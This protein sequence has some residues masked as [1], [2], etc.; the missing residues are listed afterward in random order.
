MHT[1]QYKIHMLKISEKRKEKS[2]PI[3]TTTGD[4]SVTDTWDE[5]PHRH[6]PVYPLC[7]TFYHPF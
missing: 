7:L 2:L 4:V 1:V 6:T 5:T 3:L